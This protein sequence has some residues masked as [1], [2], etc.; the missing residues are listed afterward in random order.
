[1]PTKTRKSPA[2][3]NKGSRAKLSSAEKEKRRK[4]LIESR[5]K[6]RL[7]AENEKLKSHNSPST[8]NHVSSS[9]SSAMKKR[10]AA[11]SPPPSSPE[12]ESSPEGSRMTQRDERRAAEVSPENNKGHHNRDDTNRNIVEPGVKDNISTSAGKSS[13]KSSRVKKRVRQSSP[14]LE[15]SDQKK[16]DK[17]DVQTIQNTLIVDRKS[18]NHLP[19]FSVKQPHLPTIINP[20]KS[21]VSGSTVRIGD[22]TERSAFSSPIGR[23]VSHVPK[24]KQSNMIPSKTPPRIIQK[25]YH[26]P[27]QQSRKGSNLLSR[28]D[29][30]ES[31]ISNH[32]RVKKENDKMNKQNNERKFMD[33]VPMKVSILDFSVNVCLP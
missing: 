29:T 15:T 27:L 13:R 9:V 24:V 2:D 7:W 22:S 8:T 19:K 4:R 30:E 6:A 10:K 23:V 20:Y 33:F 3:S 28:T 17:L 5:E 25:T 11:A 1:M 31:Q 14:V 12:S 32:T 21:T 16:H 18:T 26:I